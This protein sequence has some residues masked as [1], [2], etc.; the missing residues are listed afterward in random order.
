MFLNLEV[1]PEWKNNKN[2]VALVPKNTPMFGIGRI[3]LYEPPYITEV[4][5]DVGHISGG[6]PV[7]LMGRGMTLGYS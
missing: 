4:W 7:Y 6:T 1:R 2:G 5:P 3:L